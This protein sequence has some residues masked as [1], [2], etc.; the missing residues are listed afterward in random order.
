VGRIGG[1]RKDAPACL[2]RDDCDEILVT[3]L[4]CNGDLWVVSFSEC[5]SSPLLSHLCVV[6]SVFSLLLMRLPERK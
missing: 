1:R 4:T 5:L 3:Q 2:A 6:S